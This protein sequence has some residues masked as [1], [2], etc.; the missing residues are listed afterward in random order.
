MI[1][2][3]SCYINQRQDEAYTLYQDGVAFQKSVESVYDEID[4]KIKL[5]DFL[6]KTVK[7]TQKQFPEVYRIVSEL[8]ADMNIESPNGIRNR[9]FIYVKKKNGMG[10]DKMQE[11]IIDDFESVEESIVQEIDEKGPVIQEFTYTE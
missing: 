1:M 8:S 3:R 7:V 2:E 11:K 5:P 6:G 10:Y 4:F 9:L